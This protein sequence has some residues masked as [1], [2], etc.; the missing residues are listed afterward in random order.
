MRLIR[1]YDCGWILSTRTHE[2]AFGFDWKHWDFNRWFWNRAIY[3]VQVGV[4]Y[5]VRRRWRLNE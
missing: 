3:S 2:T 5:F 4:F 1:D